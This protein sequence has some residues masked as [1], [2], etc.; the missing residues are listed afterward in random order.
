MYVNE[1]IKSAISEAKYA[2]RKEPEVNKY[3]TIYR[4]KYCNIFTRANTI[5]Y[6][7]NNF[8]NSHRTREIAHMSNRSI[9]TYSYFGIIG[10][11]DLVCNSFHFRLN[12]SLLLQ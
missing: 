4:R 10:Q 2:S 8:K 12:S 1:S 7:S 11:N 6:C 5:F 9:L 3:M